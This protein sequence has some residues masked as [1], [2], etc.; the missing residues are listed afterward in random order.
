MSLFVLPS[1]DYVK[2][3]SHTPRAAVRWQNPERGLGEWVERGS[4][5]RRLI[6]GGGGGPCST[7]APRGEPGDARTRKWAQ[8]RCHHT[9]R[10]G[11]AYRAARQQ[12]GR[13][14][15]RTRRER[16]LSRSRGGRC[17]AARPPSARV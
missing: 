7:A 9:D 4:S 15:G 17:V 16:R 1:I 3:T 14:R 12:F 2:R 11:S 13:S 10:D 8:L 5:A 6:A